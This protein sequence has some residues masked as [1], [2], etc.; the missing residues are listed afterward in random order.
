MRTEI[1]ID[2][3]KSLFGC[4]VK[5]DRKQVFYY[6]FLLFSFLFESWF[7]KENR[8]SEVGTIL[9]KTGALIKIR[10]IQTDISN[11]SRE[12]ENFLKARAWAFGKI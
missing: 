8:Y 5:P 1:F 6:S 10:Y 7:H 9:L 3:R 11:D 2:S 12:F 4:D